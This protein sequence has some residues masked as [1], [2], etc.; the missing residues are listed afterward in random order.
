MHTKEMMIFQKKKM[1]TDL[2]L[3]ALLDYIILLDHGYHM[4]HVISLKKQFCCDL[5][6]SLLT[7]ENQVFL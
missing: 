7:S 2:V 3:L 1:I 4:K 5:E 6:Y